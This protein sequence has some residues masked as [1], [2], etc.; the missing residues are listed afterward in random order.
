MWFGFTATATAM[1][2]PQQNNDVQ[3]SWLEVNI[4]SGKLPKPSQFQRVRFSSMRRWA[5]IASQQARDLYES[6]HRQ[7]QMSCQLLLF[8]LETE[9][10]LAGVRVSEWFSIHPE[11]GKHELAGAKNEPGNN[12]HIKELDVLMDDLL[13][14]CS[15]YA[16]LLLHTCQSR[17]GTTCTSR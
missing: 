8:H 17:H 14:V 6:V 1:Q 11:V 2:R 3:R 7:K 5:A 4:L 9:V 13:L 10:S 15:K 12:T 16:R